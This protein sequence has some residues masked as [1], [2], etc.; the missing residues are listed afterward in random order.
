MTTH[1]DV[2]AICS[3]L[4]GALEGEGRFGFGVLVRGQHKGFCWTWMERLEP[5]KPRVE[6]PRVLA[7]RTP[8]LLAKQM[9]LESDPLRLFDE[10]HYHGF[11]AVLVRLDQITPE[12]LEPHLIEAWKTVASKAAIQAY[13]VADM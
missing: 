7:V 12:E 11:P 1:D 2:R 6:N 8:G 5:K 9:L 10:P 13:G 4:P 3:R